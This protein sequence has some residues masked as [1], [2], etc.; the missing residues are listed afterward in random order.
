MKAIRSLTL[1]G[2]CWQ[3]SVKTGLVVSLGLVV[4]LVLR[5]KFKLKIRSRLQPDQEAFEWDPNKL[6]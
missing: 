4:K 1:L 3:I 6:Q 5:L 2:W